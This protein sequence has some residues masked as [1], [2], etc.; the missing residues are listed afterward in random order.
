VLIA[1]DRTAELW[2]LRQGLGFLDDCA[3]DN[4]RKKRSF[5]LKKCR[6]AIEIGQR[7]S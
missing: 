6:K 3:G 5:G 4:R 7:A 1:L 2:M